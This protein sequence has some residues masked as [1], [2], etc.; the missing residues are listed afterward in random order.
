MVASWI[1]LRSRVPGELGKTYFRSFKVN[2]MGRSHVAFFLI[3]CAFLFL[4]KNVS[5]RKLALTVGWFPGK[6]LNHNRVPQDR[7]RLNRDGA[8]IHAAA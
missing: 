5:G 7:L 4:Q 3:C 8:P 2:Q 1:N 6:C